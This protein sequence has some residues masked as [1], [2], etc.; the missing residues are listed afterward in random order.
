MSIT[1]KQ[2]H[3]E[4]FIADPVLAAWALFRVELDVFQ[5]A[6]LRMMWFCPEL[7]DDSGVSTGKTEILWIWAQLRAILLPQPSPYPKRII[8]IYYP[9][10]DSAQSN[11]AP[12]YDKYIEVS[13]E[14]RRELR[15]THGGKLG[16]QALKG[17]IQWV[18]RNGSIIQ[19]PAANLAQDA[20]NQ[21]SKRFHDLGLDEAK[22]MDGQSNA[23]DNQIL[24]R[25]TAPGWNNS[26]PIWANHVV[27][28]GHAE[29]PDTHP[30]YR[31]VLAY[32]RLIRDGSTGH[33][34]ITSS[35]RD[36]APAFRKDYLPAAKIRQARLTMPKAKFHQHWEGVWECGTEEWYES[37]PMRRC[38]SRQV[39]VLTRRASQ[40]TLFGL[41]WDSAPGSNAKADLNA[42]VVWAADPLPETTRET[43]GVLRILGRAWRVWPCWAVQVLGR[44]VGQLSGIIHRI[45]QRFGCSRIVADPGGGGLWVQ[46]E[47]WKKTQHFDGMDQQV[48][49]ICTPETSP[50]YPQARPILCLFSRGSIDLNPVWQEDR[51]RGSDEGIIEAIHRLAQGYFENGAIS[52][53][54]PR[55]G[56]PAVDFALMEA[57]QR[58][59]LAA[60]TAT[61]QQ[62]LT[63]KVVV[64]AN[65]APAMTRR[66]FL[67]FTAEGKKKKDLAYAALY[68]LAALL[69]VLMDPERQDDD[70]DAERSMVLG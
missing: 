58:A 30:F 1:L 10:L 24:S 37:K 23:L 52:W 65:G 20:E 22:V 2:S 47:L 8:G 40:T 12:K 45:D 39:P 4:A 31:R 70:E 16:Y 46:K 49:G 26:H 33:G 7:I 61:F 41:G 38:L 27:L 19:C 18:F 54:A 59:A 3:L 21:A 32:R 36:W 69:S 53:P 25:G 13:P 28:M 63:I 51:F 60:L 44:D 55:E 50:L 67:R 35:F 29:D 34:I 17:A 48:T 11:F 62:F 64:D 57:E 15:V 6:R 42:G 5:R 43:L 66:G 68:G 9:T 14:F 56:R